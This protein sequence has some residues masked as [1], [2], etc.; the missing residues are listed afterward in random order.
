MPEFEV[1]TLAEAM[2][3]L[4]LLVPR[5]QLMMSLPFHPDRRTVVAGAVAALALPPPARAAREVTDSAGRKVGWPDRITRVFAAGGPASVAVYVLRPDTLVGWPREVREEE[6]PFVVP[7]VRDLPGVGMIT[8]R[9]DTAN[10]ELLL[11]TRPDVIVDFGSTRST[12]VSLAESVQSR[13]GI[14]YVLIDGRFEATAQSL[15]L[16][17]AMLGVPERGEELAAFTE[18]VFSRV[19]KA[20]T[21]VPEAQRPK[22][23]LARGPNGLETGLKGSINTEV[24]ER[25]GGINVADPVDGRRNIANVSPEQ[26]L[27]WNPD[28][29]VT[30][31]RNFFDRVTRQPDPF[32][33]SVKAVRDKRIHLAPTA[34]FGWIDRPPSLNRLI[35]LGWLAGLFHPGHFAFDI[36]KDTRAF[37]KL[38]YQVDVGDALL[39]TLVA[40]AD[41]KPPGLPGKR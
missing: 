39:A 12:F 3:M 14:P 37:Y 17:G 1:L 19:D 5:G 30:W 2:P 22:V 10:V 23:Y 36:E 35:G 24:I 27:L 25:A 4:R 32:W 26:V 38:F 21:A 33:Q 7:S 31:D 18:G 13:T 9:G 40:W 8:G 41:G 20:V 16:L 15:R 11:L 6:K 29:I 28:V 34:P